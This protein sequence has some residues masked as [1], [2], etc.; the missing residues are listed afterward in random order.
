MV[1]TFAFHAA[2]TP[3]GK[4]VGVPIPVAPVVACVILFNALLMQLAPLET[5]LLTVVTPT[6]MLLLETVEEVTQIALL[7]NSQL[8]TSPFINPASVYKE[9]LIPTFTPFFFH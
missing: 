1:I 9:L 3:D 2:V 8:I 7:V 6:V 5:A 4:P